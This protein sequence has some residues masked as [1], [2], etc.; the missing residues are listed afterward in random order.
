MKL[1]DRRLNVAVIG[2][3][4]SGIAAAYLL[5][6]RHRVTLYEKNDYFG[7]HTHT[8]DVPS[9]PDAGTPVDTGFIVLNER[10]YPRFIRFLQRLSVEREKTD[11]SLSYYEPDS[12]FVYATQDLVTLFAQKSNLFKPGYWRFLL[13]IRS[14]ILRTRADY[15]AGRLEGITLEEYLR[16]CGYS[17]HMIHRFIVP[18]SAA[19]WSAADADM[20]A[21]PMQTFAQ[22][23][24]N[25]G[26][27]TL[28]REV[29]WYFVKGG[30]RTYVRAFLKNFEGT[31]AVDAPV[32][33]IRRGPGVTI[34]LANGSSESYDK[35]VV[36]TH[37]DEALKL[38]EDPS[39]DER[40]LLGAWNY[41]RNRVVLHTDTRWMPK[42]RN[43]WA[44]WNYI[45]TPGTDGTAPITVTYYMNRLQNLITRESYLVTLNPSGPIPDG[46][47]IREIHYTHPIYT[48]AAFASQKEL[49]DLNGSRNTY[50]CGAYF[51]YGFHEDGV[52]SAV[53]VG[54]HF[55]V[56]L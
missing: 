37:A 11:M 7:G 30:S 17:R 52:K 22:F 20:M 4:I 19:I 39:P 53:A 42:N 31:A 12:G 6:Q 10:T 1:P 35:V 56:E 48:F 44:S 45:R 40:R 41:S 54:K 27:L 29:P 50:Y 14:F 9:G 26:L 47:I 51:G 38:L 5:Q 8:V 18:W 16:R 33:S 43:A 46:R 55:G 3:G 23:Y 28:R 13:E 21:F 32:K 15:H 36:A 49:A 24:E 2:A 25:H 34:T